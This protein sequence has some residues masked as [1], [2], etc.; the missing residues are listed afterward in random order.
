[1]ILYD[2]NIKKMRRY[3]FEQIFASLGWVSDYQPAIRQARSNC[4]IYENIP[5]GPVEGRANLLDIYRPKKQYDLMPILICI[6]GGGFTTCS[7][8]THRAVALGYA[9]RGYLVFN[10]NY[11]LAPKYRYPCALEDVCRAY[12]WIVQNAHQYGG[13]ISKLAIAGESAGG[14]LTLALALACCYETN[15]DAAQ[16]AWNTG[17]TPKAIKVLCG[18][19]QVSNPERLKAERSNISFME[20][21][22]LNVAKD[23]SIAYL[24]K[25][26]R[27]FH[28]DR[29]LADP[30]LLLS[31]DKMPDRQ[32]PVIFA[33][34][35]ENDILLSDTQRLEKTLIEKNI[36]HDVHYYPNEDHAFHLLFWKEQARQA[37]RDG[38]RFLSKYCDSNYH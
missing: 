23:V 22:H 28:E 30:L 36:P 1:M 25:N 2:F 13:N 35:G 38:F 18:L 27:T 26:F 8:E 31:S 33:M 37:W 19:L 34:V 14:N 16:R 21:F 24:G 29:A 20:Q 7:K 5:Y 11:R 3:A 4:L 12:E 6:H 9:G 17:I 15:I 32:L 10:I